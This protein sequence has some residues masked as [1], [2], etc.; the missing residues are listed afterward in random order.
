MATVAHWKTWPLNDDTRHTLE[1]RVRISR[2]VRSGGGKSEP[3]D[4]VTS[5]AVRAI[6]LLSPL[7][8]EK[9]DIESDGQACS[10]IVK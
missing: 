6:F 8:L 1:E 7:R 10:L 4:F 2:R 3:A 5:P 9:L